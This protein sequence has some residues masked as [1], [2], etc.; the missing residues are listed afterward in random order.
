MV[1]VWWLQQWRQCNV[2]GSLA[3]ARQGRQQRQQQWRQRISQWRQALDGGYGI[4]DGRRSGNAT[5]TMAMDSARATAI[6]GA[7][8]TQQQQNVQRRCISNARLVV[9]TN[10]EIEEEEIMHEQDE[11]ALPLV[12]MPLLLHMHLLV[13]GQRFQ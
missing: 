9:V 3:A 1:A 10:I 7:T 2:G 12:A 8:V 4:T 6:D 13:Q 5:A 11:G